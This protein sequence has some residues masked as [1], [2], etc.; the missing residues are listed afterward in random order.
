MRMGIYKRY[1]DKFKYNRKRREH[2]IETFDDADEQIAF[3]LGEEYVNWRD[4][5]P[6][7][8]EFL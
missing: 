5:I 3:Y 6:G 4:A 7:V 8:R 1:W 2:M